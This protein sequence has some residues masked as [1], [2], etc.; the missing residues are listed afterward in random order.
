MPSRRNFALEK[1]K[2]KRVQDEAGLAALRSAY[3]LIPTAQ[4]RRTYAPAHLL[5]A[6]QCAARATAAYVTRQRGSE[7]VLGTEYPRFM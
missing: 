4:R 5:A 3:V 1:E 2:G 7:H 6:A